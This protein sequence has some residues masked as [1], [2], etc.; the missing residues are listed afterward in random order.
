[1]MRS[2][3]VLL[4]TCVLLDVYVEHWDFGAMRRCQVHYTGIYNWYQSVF[5]LLPLLLL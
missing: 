3:H 1:M 2:L 5:S 4:Q